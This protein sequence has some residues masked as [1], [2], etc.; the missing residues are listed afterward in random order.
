MPN[1]K[2]KTRYSWIIVILIGFVLLYLSDNAYN[3][4]V[5]D[6]AAKYHSWTTNSLNVRG[7]S[8]ALTLYENDHGG[9]LPDPDKW[10]N[11]LMDYD[12]H[13][14]TF[15][16]SDTDC[17]EGETL[18]ALNKAVIGKKYSVLP[19]DLVLL[20]E[21]EPAK[22]EGERSYPFSQRTFFDD[23]V[24]E[25]FESYFVHKDRW[26][27]CSGPERLMVRPDLEFAYI[28][29]AD[30]SF[31]KVRPQKLASLRW[32]LDNTD[33]SDIFDKKMQQFYEERK[34]TFFNSRNMILTTTGI[35]GFVTLLVLI[36]KPLN[37]SFSFVAL[38]LCLLAIGVGGY[39]GNLSEHLH[40]ITERDQ[41][42]IGAEIGVI[43]G[44]T[45]GLCYCAL[46]I[47]LCSRSKW[48]MLKTVSLGMLTGVICSSIVHINL[49]L[50][51]NGNILESCLGGLFFGIAS[52]YALGLAFG[53]CMLVANKLQNEAIE[54]KQ[55]NLA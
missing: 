37:H 22:N 8:T 1:V 33:Y 45:A 46:G 7:I 12:M 5:Y 54:Q 17:I 23:E 35:L 21:V 39:Y 44:L 38:L 13:L 19:S 3:H 43:S 36:V 49:A 24:Y 15:C 16:N 42:R 48:Y 27:I 6:I 47:R 30:F 2:P 20:F 50:V 41:D 52:G 53:V 31:E 28:L 9:W 18:F 55:Q 11:Q 51:S 32:D 10:C 25:G 4:A 40:P 29:Y 26:N 14:S 34:V